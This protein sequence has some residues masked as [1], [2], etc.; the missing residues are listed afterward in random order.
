MDEDRLVFLVPQTSVW[1]FGT[2]SLI[3]NGV[4]VARKLDLFI[5][6]F[7]S[8]DQEDLECDILL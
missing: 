5:S 4:N 2:T 8:D 7:I 3:I 1:L 6:D